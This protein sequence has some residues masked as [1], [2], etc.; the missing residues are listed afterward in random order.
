MM[1]YLPTLTQQPSPTRFLKHERSGLVK[2]GGIRIFLKR[3]V[4]GPYFRDHHSR[5]WAHAQSPPTR[6]SD[7]GDVSK[8]QISSTGLNRWKGI[9]P[10]RHKRKKESLS[11]CTSMAL[12]L[13]SRHMT[14]IMSNS[15]LSKDGND[16]L[17]EPT[18]NQEEDFLASNRSQLTQYTSGGNVEESH[19]FFDWLVRSVGTFGRRHKVLAEVPAKKRQNEFSEEHNDGER[20]VNDPDGQDLDALFT[21][22]T[23]SS[24]VERERDKSSMDTFTSTMPFYYDGKRYDETASAAHLTHQDDLS[25]SVLA[26]KVVKDCSVSSNNN[27]SSVADQSGAVNP[28]FP[29]GMSAGEQGTP[30]MDKEEEMGSN[31][32]REIGPSS[33]KLHQAMKTLAEAKPPPFPSPMGM[34]GGVSEV[35]LLTPQM[36]EALQPSP[37]IRLPFINSQTVSADI[38]PPPSA[39][40]MGKLE[41]TPVARE[42]AELFEAAIVPIDV[43]N[44]ID[45]LASRGDD[46]LGLH[47][48]QCYDI[49]EVVGQAHCR[50]DPFIASLPER[51]LLAAIDAASSVQTETE[52]NLI[53]SSHFLSV[54]VKA[55]EDWGCDAESVP[56]SEQQSRSSTGAAAKALSHLVRRFNDDAT[57]DYI[58]GSEFALRGL[59]YMIEDPVARKRMGDHFVHHVKPANTP[60]MPWAHTELDRE[61]DGN[62]VRSRVFS[63]PEENALTPQQQQEGALQLLLELAHASDR[64]V[65]MFRRIDGLRFALESVAGIRNPEKESAAQ[66]LISRYWNSSF[67]TTRAVSAIKR[68]RGRGMRKSTDEVKPSPASKV[69]A[70]QLLTVLGYHT[71]IPKVPGQKG[72]RILAMD[73]GGTRGVLTLEI[74]NQ[75]FS[76]TGKSP[77]EVF[78]VICGTST[79][80]VIAGLFAVEKLDIKNAMKMYEDLI[81]K[82]FAKIAWS[83]LNLVVKQAQY[84]SEGWENI[85]QEIL[86]D[87]RMI[88][89]ADSP[90]TPKLLMCSTVFNKL[91][92]SLWVWRNYNIVCDEEDSEN[93]TENLELRGADGTFRARV[94]ECMRATSAAPSYFEPLKYGESLLC[95]GALLVNNPAALALKEAKKI[96]PGVPIEALVSIGTGNLEH[97]GERVQMGWNTVLNQ[98]LH[99]AT[100]TQ[101]VNAILESLLPKGCYYRFN[102]A[103]KRFNI[104]ETN[105][106]ELNYLKEKVRTHFTNDANHSKLIE[107]RSLL[108][109]NI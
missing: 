66:N 52:L 90:E 31:M 78:D 16:Y 62:R 21:R 86:G 46:E 14:D 102:C 3:H 5:Y 106:K 49:E 30:E 75:I 104:D 8:L 71:W 88:D 1:C 11:V 61:R 26:E 44:D 95:D 91:P 69:L 57:T 64:A 2:Q 73:G 81:L 6:F 107:L 100:D 87:K 25:E 13:L 103:I 83:A 84:S 28:F 35:D 108:T 15:A 50:I 9:L 4:F 23:P 41:V 99:G 36:E 12:V 24:T 29:L 17:I 19:S 58:L 77:H 53:T 45:E 70:Y 76:G 27:H 74:L 10:L 22:D 98:I 67:V 89:S 79:G 7:W 38:L 51:E 39:V 85:L 54:L 96:Y 63:T 18:A 72:L 47:H 42:S 34:L 68:L 55:I 56:I 48:S 65:S 37:W 20:P 40:E 93:T 97:T 101:E 60:A 94:H 80:G 43:Q 109:G 82:V 59:K 92:L 32:E 33:K 105:Q